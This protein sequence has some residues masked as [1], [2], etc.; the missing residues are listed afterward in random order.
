MTKRAISQRYCVAIATLA[1]VNFALFVLVLQSGGK[2][3]ASRTEVASVPQM[4]TLSTQGMRQTEPRRFGDSRAEL[5]STFSRIANAARLQSHAAEPEASVAELVS[6]NDLSAFDYS[7][8]GALLSANAGKVP[9]SGA[10]LWNAL[11][12]LGEF[13]QLPIPF[14]AVALDSGLSHPRVVMAQQPAFMPGLARVTSTSRGVTPRISYDPL[15]NASVNRPNLVGRLFLAANMLPSGRE[16]RVGTVE[17]ISWNSRFKKYDFGIIDGIG[18]T[19]VIKLVDGVRCFSCHKNKGPILGNNPWSNTSHNDVV[20]STSS[21]RFQFELKDD[22]V[23]LLRGHRESRDDIDGMKL[24]TPKAAE[25]D[26]GVRAAA[27]LLHNREIFRAL[28]RTE[29]GRDALRLL[30][31]AIVERGSLDAINEISRIQINRLDLSQFMYEAALINRAR[32]SS[33]LVDF[34]PAGS[35]G[36]IRQTGTSWGGT[37]NLVAEYDKDRANGK[38][39]MSGNHLPSSPNAFLKSPFYPPQQPSDL[40]SSVKLARTIGLTTADRTFLIDALTAAAWP[41]NGEHVSRSQLA[42]D[43]FNGVSFDDFIYRGEMPDR[44]DFKDRFLAELTKSMKSRHLAVE[45]SWSARESYT[46]G[47]KVDASRNRDDRS[48]ER[49]PTTSCLRCHD[50]K[51]AGKAGFSGPIP[52]LAF[53][54]FNK[55]SREAWV[56]T[57]DKKRKEAVLTRM[58]KRIG[59]DRDMPPEDSLEFKM[60]RTKNPAAFKKVEQFLEAELKKA[61]ELGSPPSEGIRGERSQKERAGG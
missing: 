10:E 59:E 48:A 15:G 40:V 41:S 38:H 27:D 42:L 52:M 24:L 54:P 53:D 30:L 50:V 21:G 61:S 39:G 49:I 34:S 51:A 17:F 3:R 47:P 57:A 43:V 9:D 11:E 28:T 44:D 8:I 6:Q 58:L 33:Q 5:G 13:V 16:P 1:A 25:I 35:I 31:A 19:P 18:D 37:I 22:L 14:S 32:V 4:D 45:S 7:A 12:K 20:R 46:S 60:F 55:T 56:A 23:S 26:A 29:K 2:P 36:I